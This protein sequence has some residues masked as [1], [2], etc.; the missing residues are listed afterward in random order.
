VNVLFASLLALHGLIHLLGF[1]KGVRLASLPQLTQPISPL[2]GFVWLAAAILF[3]AAAAALLAWPRWW[4]APALVA[5][6]VSMAVIVPSWADAK[7]GAL[8]NAVIL[9]G[10]VIGLLTQGPLSLRA[11]YEREVAQRLGPTTR[12]DLVSEADIASLPAPVRR[13]LHRT[14]VVGQPR[15]HNLRARLHGR[16]R[17]GPASAWMPFTA[18]QH[19]VFGEPA[20]LFYLRASMRGVPVHGLHAFVG[21]HATMHVKAAGLVT[22]AR[23]AGPEMDQA[24]TVTLFN[25]MC[26]LAPAT[27]IDPAI[28]WEPLDDRRAR[29]AFTHAGRTI[30]AELQFTADGELVD[31]VSDDRRALSTDG[32]TLRAVRWS[33]PLRDYRPFGSVRL[34][35]RGEGRWHEASG[36]Y[37]YIELTVDGVEYNVPHP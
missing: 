26:V 23:A 37:A 14:G 30:R 16:I 18:E 22:V 2:L 21:P 3:V 8:V 32:T 33:T 5:L 6:A 9:L 20:R 19:N 4:W 24:E 11:Q 17:S 35:S 7:A 34:A 28:A 29:A 31:F 1:A 12:G 25:D 36:T 15:V 27:L 13:Y 10:V